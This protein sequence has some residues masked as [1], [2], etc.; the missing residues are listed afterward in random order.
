MT[1]ET[2]LVHT[3]AAHEDLAPD[4]DRVLAEVRDRTRNRH[5]AVRP[6]AVAATVAV[7]AG[8]A[9]GAVALTSG[10]HP[11]TGPAAASPGAPATAVSTAST[12]AAPA[13]PAALTM[14]FDI[15]GLPEGTVSYYA[16]RVQ[17]AAES[18]SAPAVR[19]GEYLLNVTSATRSL[20]VDVQQMPGG[21]AGFTFK[22]GPG[23]DVTIAGRQGVESVDAGGPGGYE[24]Y[25][26]GPD[27]RTVYV[28]VANSNNGVARPAASADE[29]RADGRRVAASVR[30]PGTTT[31]TPEYGV[32]YVPAGLTLRTFEVAPGQT[33]TGDPAPGTRTS[34]GL[35]DATTVDDVISIFPPISEDGA[36]TPGRPVQGHAT[37]VKD[38]RGFV[39]LVVVG[40]LPGNDLL[41]EGSV[42]SS[43][44]YA[45]ADG[46][47]LP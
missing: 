41:L 36:F 3:F 26:V 15:G 38:E 10:G 40:A 12:A 9:A 29:L 28:N 11:A 1:L 19:D 5:T 42:P 44:L 33:A 39:S 13:G 43:E 20:D 14:P 47:V 2:D 34:Y 4:A 27:G 22:S 23:A 31:L 17:M 21:V 37:K 8:V 30:I 24:V 45:V 46:L 16:R 6:W 35:G 32:G 25:V 18:D 7:M